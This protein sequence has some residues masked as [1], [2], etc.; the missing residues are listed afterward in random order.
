MSDYSALKIGSYHT[1]L[2]NEPDGEESVTDDEKSETPE[3]HL[4]RMMEE[5][6]QNTLIDVIEEAH[7]SGDHD[8]RNQLLGQLGMPVEEWEN[9]I[10]EQFELAKALPEWQEMSNV[11]KA[12]LESWLRGENPDYNPGPEN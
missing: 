12:E 7:Y 10:E 5:G 11:E 1:Q 2:N 6:L 4:V 3:D 9:A 8:R